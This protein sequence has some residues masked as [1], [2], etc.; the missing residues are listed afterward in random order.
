MGILKMTEMSVYCAQIGARDHYAFA[1]AFHHAG[2]LGG[3]I[4]DYWHSG[5]LSLPGSFSPRAEGR[6]H[7]RLDD[8]RV[9]SCNAQTMWRGLGLRLRGVSGWHGVLAHN[10]GFQKDALCH[11]RRIARDIDPET[12]VV[13]FSYSYAARELFAFAKDHGWATL[14]GQIDPGPEEGQLVQA[15]GERHFDWQCTREPPPP[16]YYPAWREETT[17]ADR[18]IVNSEWSAAALRRTGV[19]PAKIS[20]VPIPYD[21][22]AWV[23]T[24]KEFPAVFSAQRPLRVLFLGQVNLR[25]G[26]CEL[27]EAMSLLRGEPVELT[28]VG[29]TQVTVPP[30]LLSLPS[31][32]WM[33]PVP[34]GEASRYFHHADVFILPTHSDGFG[35]TQLEALAHRLPVIVS[36]NCARL[37]QDDVQGRVLTGFSPAAIADVLRS[38]LTH[39]EHLPRWSANC[40]VPDQCRMDSVADRLY[41]LVDSL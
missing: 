41:K 30:A 10:L 25:K 19:A 38:I 16:A 35:L 34:R 13:L 21:P 27:L 24:E 14:L 31:L 28:I 9:F 20:V 26:I 4:T 18:I 40:G 33:G 23:P 32:R 15:L 2:V 3:L 5:K 7:P 29:E 11:L 37:V 6:R 8:A 22:T 39:P 36:E 1:R 17:L 12:R